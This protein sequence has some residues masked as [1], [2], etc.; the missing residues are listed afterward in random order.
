M[1]KEIREAIAKKEADLTNLSQATDTR[2]SNIEKSLEDMKNSNMDPGNAEEEDS[3]DRMGAIAQL[4][5]ELPVLKASQALLPELLS[6]LKSEEIDKIAKRQMA[7]TNVSFG[8]D[9]SGF[10]IYAN[11]APISVGTMGKRR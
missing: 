3:E 4:E 7:Y 1:T 6:R 9:N 8:N 2:L 11:H 5:R 10:Q